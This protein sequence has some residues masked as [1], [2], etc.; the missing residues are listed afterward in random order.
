MFTNPFTV[1]CYT[2]FK[3][4]VWC[5]ML[6]LYEDT[7]FSAV[8]WQF[9]FTSLFTF[10]WKQTAKNKFTARLRFAMVNSIQFIIF[11]CLRF[12]RRM[13]ESN[14]FV[15]QT[16]KLSKQHLAIYAFLLNS[17]FLSKR[18]GRIRLWIF[19]PFLGIFR[20]QTEKTPNYFNPK[21]GEKWNL[22]TDWIEDKRADEEFK[23][24]AIT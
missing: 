16:A 17:L 1:I 10:A 9:K 18:K 7:L 11:Y 19:F 21:Y 2:R 20:I 4:F 5:S 22:D 8:I 3:S 15:M 12:V 14:D 13:H 24:Y 6:N 23:I